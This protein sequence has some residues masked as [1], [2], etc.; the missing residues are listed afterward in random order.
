MDILYL[1][2]PMSLALVFVIAVIFWWSLRSGQYE[3]LDGP[4]HRVLMDD[5]SPPDESDSVR[6]DGK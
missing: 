5:D 6:S 2:I 3:D 1:L 4:G